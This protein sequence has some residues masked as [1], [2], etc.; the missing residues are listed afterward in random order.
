MANKPTASWDENKPA[1]TRDLA[2]GDD[3]IRELKQQV[4][5]I[6]AVDHVIESTGQGED[7]G[8]HKNV[9]LPAQAVDPDAVDSAAIIFSKDVDAKAEVHVKDEDGDVIQL[10]KAGKLFVADETPMESDAAPVADA[11]IANK[12]YVDDAIAANVLPAGVIAMW[13][14]T[15]LTIPDGWYLC[16]G[17]VVGAITTP[18][19]RDKFIVGAKQDDAGVAKTNITGALT[20]V[21]GDVSH[22][23]TGYTDYSGQPNEGT[24]AGVATINNHRHVIFSDDHLP[25]YYALAYIM[26]G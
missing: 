17:Q 9:T 4:R 23:H 19:L 22:D 25:P 16:N 21:G 24:A 1:G 10:T 11:G 14:G 13:S 26:K 6:L 15:I 8:Q 2:L 12:K 7:W 3:D 20:Q 5:E 18:D